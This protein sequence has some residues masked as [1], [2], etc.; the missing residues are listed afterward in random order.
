[1]AR[2]GARS[3]D[4]RPAWMKQSGVG[5]I[6]VMV[7]VL[8]LSTSLLALAAL[9][10]RSLQ[11]NHEA[12]LRSQ[13]NVLAYD[14]IDRIRVNR[15]NATQYDLGFDDDAPAGDSAVARDL[16][17]WRQRIAGSLPDG[18]SDIDCDAD[19]LC[20]VQIRWRETDGA[21]VDD[22]GD[23]GGETTTFSY[24]TRV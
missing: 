6:E 7:T 13:A 4:I 20:T 17:D 23:P 1:M 10:S 21:D 24:R 9:Q 16:R 2:D 19:G 12:Y 14:I 15:G 22:A 11:Y 5:L 8:I 18:S 3:E